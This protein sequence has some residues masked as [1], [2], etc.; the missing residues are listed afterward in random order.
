MTGTIACDLSVLAMLIQ[1]FLQPCLL[2]EVLLSS[3]SDMDG[4]HHVLILDINHHL[5][6][7]HRGHQEKKLYKYR[8][9]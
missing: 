5:P 7:H 2:V 1:W 6:Q 4:L 8:T 3:R 9:T